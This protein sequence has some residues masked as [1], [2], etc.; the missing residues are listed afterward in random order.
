M[1]TAGFRTLATTEK[2]EADI[3]GRGNK[4]TTGSAQSRY[5]ATKTIVAATAPSSTWM[6]NIRRAAADPTVCAGP[7]QNAKEKG[8]GTSFGPPQ[9]PNLPIKRKKDGEDDDTKVR[10]HRLPRLHLTAAH[11]GF[12]KGHHF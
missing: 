2:K 5:A 6:Q 9:H 7:T 8:A 1:Y 12:L 10:K 4:P 11:K 3:A